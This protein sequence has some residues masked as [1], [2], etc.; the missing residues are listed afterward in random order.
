VVLLGRHAVGLLS[1]RELLPLSCLG[2][3][4]RGL[5]FAS[6]ELR[7]RLPSRPP[8][9]GAGVRTRPLVRVLRVELALSEAELEGVADRAALA[10]VVD[11]GG[12]LRS[13]L[14]RSPSSA[15]RVG[16]RS[17][18]RPVAHRRH[19]QPGEDP[20]AV[21]VDATVEAETDRDPELAAGRSVGPNTTPPDPAS[22]RPK[23]TLRESVPLQVFV[24]AGGGTRT[25]DTR[26]MMRQRFGFMAR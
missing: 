3:L 10:V 17:D 16:T 13:N 4:L 21:A 22:S 7:S 23:A 5:N 14:A 19:L 12:V 8:G 1:Y 24:D 18:G 15:R 6:G 26:I 20:D 2:A 11:A 25:P 9:V